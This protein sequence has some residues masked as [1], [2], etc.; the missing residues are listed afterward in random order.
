MFAR[1]AHVS[2]R[3][4]VRAVV[5]GSFLFLGFLGLTGCATGGADDDEPIDGG[6][7]IDAR[8]TDGAAPVDAKVVDAAPLVD[9][10]GDPADAG[11]FCGDNEDCVDL[12]TCCLLQL[13]VPGTRVEIGDVTCIPEL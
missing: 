12:A 13:C 7:L 1:E 8:I 11:F 6:G 5:I 2:L 4:I 3:G 10:P 9:A